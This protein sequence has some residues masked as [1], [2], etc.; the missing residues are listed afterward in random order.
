MKRYIFLVC[1]GFFAFKCIMPDRKYAIDLQNNSNHPI[2][3]YVAA[4]GMEHA[5]P[6][7]ALQ[8]SKPGMQSIQPGKSAAWYISLP[9]DRF[10]KELPKDTLSIYVFHPD[11][12]NAY[13]WL[14]IRDQYKILK[15]YDLSLQDLQ[16]HNFIITYP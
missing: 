16:D 1:I 12:L 13:D 7:T 4:L 8:S 6:D 3:F 9:F 11:T 14:I 2:Y 10:F 5:Y 15:R